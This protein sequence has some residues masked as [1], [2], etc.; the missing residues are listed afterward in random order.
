MRA[1]RRRGCVS[2]SLASTVVVVAAATAGAYVA[3]TVTAHSAWMVV[4]APFV[5]LGLG[6][7]LVLVHR[8]DLGEE[9]EHVLLSDS[10]ILAA[11]AAWAVV[12]AV[13]LA[14]T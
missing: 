6:R 4:T 10:V 1:T 13:V 9:P 5:V 11:V 14:V 7:Y 2:T 3:Y 8:H 12:S